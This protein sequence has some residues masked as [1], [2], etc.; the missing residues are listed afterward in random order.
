MDLPGILSYKKEKLA[1]A[2]PVCSYEAV[3]LDLS[4]V[5]ARRE[6]FRRVGAGGKNVLTVTEGLLIYLTADE[7][8]ALATD[9]RAQ[10]T[11][12]R[13][14]IDIAS[15]DL[16]KILQK[17]YGKDLSNAGAPLKFA[18][19][20]HTAFFLPFGWKTAEF[21]SSLEE[22]RRVRREMRMAWLFR[23]LALVS[24]EKKREKFRR[25]AGVALLERA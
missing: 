16:L 21:R 12:T 1:A 11:F 3:S 8:G 13:W 24:S 23:L 6:L 20:E 5:S 19:P 14:I 9:L 4:D 22:A 7:V 2:R 15:P 18:P 25:M 10:T 17:S